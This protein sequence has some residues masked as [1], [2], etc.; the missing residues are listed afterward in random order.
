MKNDKDDSTNDVEDS[1]VVI[2]EGRIKIVK[3]V[4]PKR[5]NSVEIKT[6]QVDL[7]NDPTI[8]KT[9]YDHDHHKINI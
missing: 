5:T 8:E 9:N 3:E 6:N 2:L 7:G 4:Q 1:N